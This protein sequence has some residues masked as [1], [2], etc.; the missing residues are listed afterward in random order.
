MGVSEAVPLL[1]S[2]EGLRYVI[3]VPKVRLPWRS[4]AQCQDGGER[5]MGLEQVAGRTVSLNA[6]REMS[7]EAGPS[8]NLAVNSPSVT[9]GVLVVLDGIS[10]FAGPKQSSSLGVTSRDACTASTER[11]K[12]TTETA[13]VPAAE[14]QQEGEAESEVDPPVTRGDGSSNRSETW[15]GTVTAIMGPS[16]AGKT[17]LLNA[18]AGRIHEVSRGGKAVGGRRGGHDGADGGGEQTGLTGAVRLNGVEVD[19]ED[20]RRVSAYVTQEDVLPE[21]LTCY[22]HM[23]FHAHLRLPQGTSFARRR[24]TV[25]E[26]SVSGSVGLVGG[27]AAAPELLYKVLPQHFVLAERSVGDWR[28]SSFF[29]GRGVGV[30]FWGEGGGA[31]DSYFVHVLVG[32]HCL[33]RS[34]TSRNRMSAI[35]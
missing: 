26:V 34:R 15:S 35:G 24:A 32:R 14:Q 16:G 13:I 33:C 28:F 22:E 9:N 3:T 20:V 21:T 2:W 30:R 18:L 7:V 11:A 8:D 19:A 17:S 1:L 31:S 6:D 23:M 4:K 25:V 27:R 29:G 10:G 5:E 12:A